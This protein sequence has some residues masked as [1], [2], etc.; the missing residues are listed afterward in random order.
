MT[1]VI[2]TLVDRSEADIMLKANECGFSLRSTTSEGGQ[3]IW[4]WQHHSR[5]PRPFFLSRDEAFFW[6]YGWLHSN[7]IHH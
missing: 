2:D 1:R 5:G 4:E 6:M 3:P 7:G